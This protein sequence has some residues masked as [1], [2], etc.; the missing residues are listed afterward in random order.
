MKHFSSCKANRYLSYISDNSLPFPQHQI[1]KSFTDGMNTA[2]LAKKLGFID[3][4]SIQLH[5]AIE[6]LRFLHVLLES[7]FN[8]FFRTG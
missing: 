5:H 2:S 7:N 3:K 8:K 4:E 6:K 1:S